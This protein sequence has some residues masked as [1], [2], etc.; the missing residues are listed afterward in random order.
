MNEWG[1]SKVTSEP[2]QRLPQIILSPVQS[3][4]GENNLLDL[5]VVKWFK[6]I[7][8]RDKPLL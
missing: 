5:M 3:K 4:P 7:A 6:G 8:R 1:N 2:S